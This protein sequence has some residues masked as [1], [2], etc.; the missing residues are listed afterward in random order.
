MAEE[1]KQ[2]ARKPAAK[3]TTARSPPPR[4]R[5]QAESDRRH[6]RA[7]RRT[8]LLHLGRRLR[9]GRLR[10]LD[11][12]RAR[13]DGRVGVAKPAR[14]G[15][16]STHHRPGTR[17]AS[18]HGE[19]GS[20]VRMHG[21]RLRRRTV[22]RQMPGL[23]RV[24][25]ARRGDARLGRPCRSEAAAPP[26]R[27]RRRGGDA[28]LDRRARAPTASSAAASC[29]QPRPRRG[30]P[31]VGKSTLLLSALG[32]VARGRRAL[33]VTGEES[34]AQVKLRAAASEAPSR[35][36]SSPRPSSTPSARRSSASGPTSA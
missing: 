5:P 23:Q 7:D 34:T 17:L 19:G 18:L 6:G 29:G 16:E 8:R 20:P 27:R 14:A 2:P 25:L 13:A 26:R 12:R 22:V 15:T 32:A 10:R 11:P 3:K 24:R 28:D 4:R 36:R 9:R 35:S 31:G 21:V 30:E 33:L 1:Q